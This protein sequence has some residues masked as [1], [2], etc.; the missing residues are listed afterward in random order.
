[1]TQKSFRHLL[2][3]GALLL[4]LA[5]TPPSAAQDEMQ[6]ELSL[7]L[8][9]RAEQGEAAAQF[10]MGCIYSQ[11]GDTKQAGEMLRLAAEQGH[12]Q[13]KVLYGLW[14]FREHAYEPA[15]RLL[16]ASA[17]QGDAESQFSLGYMY[18]KGWG[19][20]PQPAEAFRLFSA[21]ARQ[22]H[23]TARTMLALMHLEGKM[24]GADTQEA[25]RL[26]SGL[27]KLSEV[28]PAPADTSEED[29]ESATTESEAD[30]SPADAATADEP[31]DE[32][33]P[34][35][36]SPE[37]SANEQA[38]AEDDTTEGDT[39]EN[40]STEDDTIEGDTTE[41]DTTEDD[42]T[43]DD[44]TEDDSAEGDSTE[45]DSTED[46]STEADSAEDDDEAAAI[47][48][49]NKTT[50]PLPEYLLGL[51]QLKG[52]GV[53]E[54]D[55]SAYA[56]LEY[57]AE[58]S[59][60]TTAAC[61]LSELSERG[62]G[63]PQSSEQASA[64]ADRVEEEE[65]EKLMPRVREYIDAATEEEAYQALAALLQGS[66][67]SPERHKLIEA[68]MALPPYSVHE[69]NRDSFRKQ[70]DEGE[71]REDDGR[72]Y[73]SIEGDG[74]FGRRLFVS[75]AAGKLYI[76]CDD[77]QEGGYRI[78]EYDA[79]QKQLMPLFFLEQTWISE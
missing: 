60:N 76:V 12:Q 40:D 29:T 63:V 69:A 22:N 58:N 39:T 30:E 20:E 46:D 27:V 49:T 14:C 32:E 7:A 65:R 24:E 1:M 13:A 72:C 31:T 42:T 50:Y 66:A 75:N 26:L 44:T 36:E 54:N 18:Y 61:I 3:Q 9:R 11:K 59:D 73:L 67:A 17:E 8:Q 41:D 51:L 6:D 35:E 74:T 62:I 71:Y 10:V 21:A 55:M 47:S 56:L 70:L 33:P 43:E 45:A 23:E 28:T 4:A 57:A 48:A 25:V 68:I 34:S 38:D 78:E 5:L 79:E 53:V 19:T 77:W 2:P 16:A 64:W 15:L 52:L 37:D